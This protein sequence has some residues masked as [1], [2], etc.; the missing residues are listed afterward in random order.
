M[1]M[2][3]NLQDHSYPIQIKSG[4]LK[5]CLKDL[6][7]NRRYFVIS[8][9]GVPAKW[10]NM[11]MEQLENG[12]LFVFEQGEASKC[13]DQYQKIMEAMAASG[14]NRKDAVI[15]VGGGVAGDLAGF[16]AATYMR[17][18]DFYNIPTTLLSQLD[19]SVGGKTAIDLGTL[20]NLVG[21]F[22]QPK[23]VW[24]DPQVLETLDPRQLKAGL[25]EALKMGLILDE[26]LYREFL[27]EEPRLEWII[28]RAVDLKRKVVEEDEK[29]L[30]LRKIL[31][32][33]HTIGHA[34]ESSYEHHD[35]LHGECVAMGMLYFLKDPALKEQVINIVRKL[36]LP[37]VPCFDQD[38][39]FEALVH[40]KKGSAKGIDAI[41]VDRP[42][43]FQIESLPLDTFQK[44]LKGNVYEEHIWQ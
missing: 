32:F 4:I 8:D 11:V 24:I 16:C 20:K 43:S 18:I 38:A 17:G 6:N 30:G 3:V 29:E 2:T 1:E 25:A 13:F 19:S 41:L 23:A 15:A 26:E 22:W 34:I 35:Y 21:A 5:N 7:P 37:D 10:Q 27:K 40:D 12:T 39:V 9:S 44:L 28:Q 42:G 33:G 31:N 36:G 14:M